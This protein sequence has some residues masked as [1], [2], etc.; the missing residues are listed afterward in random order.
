MANGRYI[1]TDRPEQRVLADDVSS[2]TEESSEGVFFKKNQRSVVFETN[3]YISTWSIHPA[4]LPSSQSLA[5][6]VDVE[7]KNTCNIRH[8]V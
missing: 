6:G 7:K 2:S 5:V 1:Q 3:R 4:V 8:K